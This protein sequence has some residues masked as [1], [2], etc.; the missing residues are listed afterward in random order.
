MKRS[1]LVQKGTSYWVNWPC[2]AIC[3]HLQALL[4][5]FYAEMLKI[6]INSVNFSQKY[7]HIL[8]FKYFEDLK[9]AGCCFRKAKRAGWIFHF[10]N[11]GRVLPPLRPF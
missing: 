4:A 3:I 1:F 6:L 8:T 7:K 9:R 5:S 2:L 11:E 10:Q